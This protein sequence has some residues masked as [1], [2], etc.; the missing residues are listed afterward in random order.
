[1]RLYKDKNQENIFIVTSRDDIDETYYDY[2][3]ENEDIDPAKEMEDVFDAVFV[4]T[5]I[6]PKTSI[7]ISFIE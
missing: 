1:M 4:L 6:D 2:I 7:G 5:D 3:G